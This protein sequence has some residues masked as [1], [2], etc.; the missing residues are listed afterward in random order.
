MVEID[1]IAINHSKFHIHPNKYGST[2]TREKKI[3]FQIW[4]VVNQLQNMLSFAHISAPC[5]HAPVFIIQP[6]PNKICVSTVMDFRLRTVTILAL[7]K[8]GVFETAKPTM[9]ILL[10]PW[11]LMYFRKGIRSFYSRNIE[12]VDQ[13]ASKLLAFKVEGFTKKSAARP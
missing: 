1:K 13:R 11:I 10:D 4:I 9:K 3:K 7:C 2:K 12:S 6:P 5:N 8:W